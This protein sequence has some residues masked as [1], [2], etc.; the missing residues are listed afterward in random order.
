MVQTLINEK[1]TSRE[2]SQKKKNNNFFERCGCTVRTQK[3]GNDIP[4]DSKRSLWKRLTYHC[5]FTATTCSCV[6]KARQRSSRGVDIAPR[7]LSRQTHSVS[8]ECHLE[9]RATAPSLCKFK[10]A[11]RRMACFN[12]R[13]DP[14]ATNEDDVELLQRCRRHYC[15]VL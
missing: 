7:V 10:S 8:K 11:R 9:R 14:I 2:R 15:A 13:G 5:I 12:V 4:K 3:R 1:E 6:P